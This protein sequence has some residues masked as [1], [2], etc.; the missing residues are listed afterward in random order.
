MRASDRNTLLNQLISP[1][2]S[3][4]DL[5]ISFYLTLI[6]NSVASISI[7]SIPFLTHNS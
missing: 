3:V 7:T 6:G 1:C 5:S 2:G 4:T